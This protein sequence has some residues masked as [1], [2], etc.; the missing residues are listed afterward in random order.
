MSGRR[1]SQ[2]QLTRAELRAMGVTPGLVVRR[3]SAEDRTRLEQLTSETSSGARPS[4]FLRSGSNNC[5]KP[6]QEGD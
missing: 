3:Y 6:T 2:R 4:L 5:S 1:R